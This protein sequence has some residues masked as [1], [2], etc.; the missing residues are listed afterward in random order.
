MKRKVFLLVLFSSWVQAEED[1]LRCS[2]DA[3]SES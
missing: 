3:R 2:S 1:A